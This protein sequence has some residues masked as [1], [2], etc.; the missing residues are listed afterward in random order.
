MA[1]LQQQT[2]PFVQVCTRF[3]TSGGKTASSR[4]QCCKK[5]GC[6]LLVTEKGEEE[7]GAE[8][9]Q[10]FCLWRDKVPAALQPQIHLGC[11]APGL[12]K[13]AASLALWALTW[14]QGHSSF[15]TR[16]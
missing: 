16:H 13:A 14:Q 3:L 12:P 10:S 8:V 9:G 1:P 11:A 15:T 7:E 4:M 2:P 6:S 5:L